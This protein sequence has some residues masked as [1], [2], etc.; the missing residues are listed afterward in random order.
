M[1][2]VAVNAFAATVLGYTRA[3]SWPCGSPTSP[4]R[5]RE[6]GVTRRWSRPGSLDGVSPIRR[7]DGVVLRFRYQ[8]RQTTVAGTAFFVSIG[9]LED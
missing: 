9:F 2:Y 1:K 6:P 5:R 3:S 7:K 4:C 8:A